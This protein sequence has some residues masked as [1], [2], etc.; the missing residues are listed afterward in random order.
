MRKIIYIIIL[1]L[2]ISTGYYFSKVRKS[3]ALGGANDSLTNVRGTIIPHHDLADSMIIDAF[4][5]LKEDNDYEKI[6]IIG[7]NHFYPES[8]TIISSYSLKDYPIDKI[9][10]EKMENSINDLVL[11]QEK[12]EN[13]HSVGIPIKY[14][15]QIYPNATFVPIAVSPFYT[16]EI[17]NQIAQVLSAEV[18]DK[19]LYVLSVDF[20]HNVGVDEGLKNNEVSIDAIRNFDMDKILTFNDKYLDSPVALVL[21]LKI[22]ENFGAKN[23]TTLYSTHGSIIE[24]EPDLN[25]TS[26]VVGTFS[27]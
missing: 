3:A 16:N 13:E 24:G 8:P 15:N 5:R 11:D 10:I 27:N 6:I 9:I 23:W 4:R 14:L 19:A 12:L 25:G 18:S 7:P 20:A 21:F 1:I 26:Y 17:L 22:M 2:F